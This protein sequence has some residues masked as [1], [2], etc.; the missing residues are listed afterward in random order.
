LVLIHVDFGPHRRRPAAND[1]MFGVCV[2]GLMLARTDMV[3][4]AA[5]LMLYVALRLRLSGLRR[6]IVIAVTAAAC[7]AP[8]LLWSQL[9]TGSV[10]QVSGRAGGVQ[11]RQAVEAQYPE[12]TDRLKHSAD[13]VWSTLSSELPYAYTVP[14]DLPGT[15]GVGIFA[16]AVA[17]CTFVLWRRPSDYR[18]REAC[19]AIGVLSA[20]LVI[21]LVYHA[22]VRFFTRTWYFAPSAFLLATTVG[23]AF[24]AMARLLHEYLPLANQRKG[25]ADGL[26]LSGSALVFAIVYQPHDTMGWGGEHPH[27]LNAYE[28]ARWLREETPPDTRAGAFNA[29]IIGYFSD[30]TVLN[31]DGV[32]NEN[33][34]EALRDCEIATYIS[35]EEL[36]YLVDF[37]SY[38]PIRAS[39]GPPGVTFPHVTT[40]GRSDVVFGAVEVWR[41]ETSP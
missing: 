8:W 37:G 23:L 27:E 9:A 29:G 40:L 41:V 39:C 19:M 22:G 32:V 25:V 5:I 2:G 21:M 16:V 36:E 24:A 31:L 6:L 11:V 3:F 17:L 18:F 1:V 4:V 38:T 35:D 14:G 13:L 34:Y 20:A 7:V 12:F 28:G 15:L 33:A 10:V 26:L 30:R